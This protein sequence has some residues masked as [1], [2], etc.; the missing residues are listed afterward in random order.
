VLFRSKEIARQLR[1]SLQAVHQIVLRMR[2]R[3]GE[4]P[5]NYYQKRE[6]LI[7]FYR[8]LVFAGLLM[9][10]NDLPEDMYDRWLKD[11]FLKEYNRPPLMLIK[12]IYREF[13]L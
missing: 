5:F 4:K 2:E 13:G 1:I 11:I 7:E 3:F 6:D 10:P 8:S 9:S 12:K